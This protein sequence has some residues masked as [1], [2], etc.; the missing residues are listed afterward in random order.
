MSNPD[1]RNPFGIE[2]DDEYFDEKI[3]FQFI[4][5]SRD[6]RAR[7]KMPPFP[8]LTDDEVNNI[9]EYLRWMKGHKRMS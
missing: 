9:L 2:E 6:F 1:R 8:D 4:R 3:L 5:N 7:S